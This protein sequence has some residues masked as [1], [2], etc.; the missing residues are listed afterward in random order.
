MALALVVPSPVFGELTPVR[1]NVTPLLAVLL[2][3]LVVTRD[4]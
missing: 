2:M 4:G 1:S 3:L